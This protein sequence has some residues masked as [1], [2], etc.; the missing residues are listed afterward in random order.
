MPLHIGN[1]KSARWGNVRVLRATYGSADGPAAVVLELEDG[2]PLATLSVNM[3]EPE[4][5]ADSLNLPADCFYVKNWSENEDIARDAYA[6]GLFTLR[7][8]LGR[9]RS[10]F[11][12]A[13]V[14][15]IIEQKT[16]GAA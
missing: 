3:Y 11:V 14:W 16:G 9:A 4:C 7:D 1:F 13:P 5:S 6:S 10:G 15:Q 8:D 12:E 2:E